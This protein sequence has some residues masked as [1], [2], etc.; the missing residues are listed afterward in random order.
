LEIFY[1]NS[2]SDAC[3][4]VLYIKSTAPVYKI[5]TSVLIKDAKKMS[6][7]SG[8][9]GVLQSFGA[10]SGMGTNSIE[11]ELG[12]FQTKSIVED[13]FKE[14]NFQTPIY[15]KQTFYNLE[16][17]GSTAPYIIHYSRKGKC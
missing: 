8:D 15:A 7:A 11:N 9:F 12:V 16:L 13:V 6:S 2:S 14:H 3:F 4:A 17:Y 1:C 10:F 5:Q